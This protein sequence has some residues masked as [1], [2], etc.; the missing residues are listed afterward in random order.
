MKAFLYRH[1]TFWKDKEIR[2][3]VLVSFLLLC[4]SLLIAYF[5]RDYTNKYSG[6]IVPDILL[7][8][9]SVFDVGYVFFQGA[10]LFVV[11]LIGMLVW[12]PKYI[13]FVLESSAL[14][15]FT[16]SC[17]MLMTHLSA[18]AVEY[19]K[20]IER[21]HHASNV[22]FTVS[23]GNDLFFS[24]HAGY[25]FLLAFIFWYYKPLR[26]I[27]LVCSLVGSVAVI[28]GHLHY[29][30]DVFSAYFIAFGIFEA[31]K[32]FFK[33]EYSLLMGCVK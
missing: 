27:F 3:H 23:S 31:S 21:E 12:Q 25:P 33:K 29:T 28:L 17:F 1:S 13:P 11:G 5:A 6:N 4:I 30:I 2:H 32:Y 20:Y 9:L 15:F 7:D 24:G 26:Y 8:N 10:F 22:V 19:Y 16:R 14:F 18:P